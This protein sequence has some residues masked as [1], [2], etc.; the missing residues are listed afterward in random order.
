MIFKLKCIHFKLESS[1]FKHR[2]LLNFFIYKYTKNKFVFPQFPALA[3]HC[4][5]D[6]K[7]TAEP[8]SWDAQSCRQTWT[9]DQAPVPTFDPKPTADSLLTVIPCTHA[10]SAGQGEAA[11]VMCLV[12]LGMT[13]LWI[14]GSWI[15]LILF[16]C[17]LNITSS[18]FS[19]TV[20]VLYL[21]PSHVG[22]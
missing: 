4:G 1:S 5:Q 10:R 19:Q 2:N 14:L 12:V 7:P 13:L 16:F 21:N 6:Y 8:G 3:V 11:D 18:C 9:T 20:Y 17:L 15:C 22:R